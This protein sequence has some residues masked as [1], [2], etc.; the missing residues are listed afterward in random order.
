[1]RP[2]DGEKIRNDIALYLAENAYLNDTALDALKMVAKWLE[3]APTIEPPRWIPVSEQL[4]EYGIS[5][6]VLVKNM[7]GN[8]ISYY[9]SR[10]QL[11]I[12]FLSTVGWHTMHEMVAYKNDVLYWCPISEPPKEEI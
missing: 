9:W 8:D 11:S 12:G 10:P 5:C 6:V 1:M 4:P 2:I 3:A 7:R